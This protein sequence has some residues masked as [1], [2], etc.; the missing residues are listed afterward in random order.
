[1]K[2]RDVQVIWIVITYA[3][4]YAHDTGTGFHAGNRRSRT[5]SLSVKKRRVGSLEGDV[6]LPS[7]AGDQQKDDVGGV[8]EQG[9]R[10]RSKFF[11]VSNDKDGKKDADKGKLAY[12]LQHIIIDLD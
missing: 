12:D 7:L 2:R 6:F 10:K 3:Y 4:V 5:R 1:M 8:V 9:K 11:I